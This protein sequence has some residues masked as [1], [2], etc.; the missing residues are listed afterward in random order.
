MSTIED[1][2]VYA[3]GGIEGLDFVKYE[4]KKLLDLK[5]IDTLDKDLSLLDKEFIKR[6]LSAGGS[7]D[8]LGLTW[9]LAS[10][11]D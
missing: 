4:A 8:L 6:N 5:N 1:S 2:T 11:N 10:L 9:F 3:R 7:A